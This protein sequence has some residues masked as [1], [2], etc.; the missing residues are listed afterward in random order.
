MNF[1][2]LS[3]DDCDEYNNLFG[4]TLPNI[5][6]CAINPEGSI[7][8]VR[9]RSSKNLLFWYDVNLERTH[10]TFMM[11]YNLQ[12][13]SGGPLAVKQK[14]GSYFLAGITSFGR[15]VFQPGQPSYSTRV[16]EVRDWIK[17]TMEAGLP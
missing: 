7:S 17:T 8:R 9:L 4:R 15:R 14:D 16:S 10:C 12:G 2:I 13:D 5:M 11:N 3:N 6:I 1:S